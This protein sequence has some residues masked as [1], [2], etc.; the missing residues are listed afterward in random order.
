MK[1]KLYK[2]AKG[3]EEIILEGTLPLHPL[4]SNSDHS[5]EQLSL[6]CLP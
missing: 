2:K 6:R 1:L 3:K 5:K 4:W